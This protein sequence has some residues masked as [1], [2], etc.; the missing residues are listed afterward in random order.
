MTRVKRRTLGR[1]PFGA[2]YTCGCPSSFAAAWARSTL[3]SE[4]NVDEVMACMPC[5]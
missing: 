5:Y 2:A 4:G 1:H 3:L